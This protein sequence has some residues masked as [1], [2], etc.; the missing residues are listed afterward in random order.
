M[1][2][3]A[4]SP[5]VPADNI[6]PLVVKAA[7]KDRVYAVTCGRVPGVYSSWGRAGAQVTGFPGNILKGYA[8][9]EEAR[10]AFERA[11]ARGAVYSEPFKRA[12]SIIKAEG[13]WSEMR[14]NVDDES[15]HTH[16]R[17][18]PCIVVFRGL[19]TG[20]FDDWL[21]CAEL[22]VAVRGAIFKGYHTREVGERI[23][24]E[25]IQNGD[26]LSP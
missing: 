17:D 3:S 21:D 22:V 4:D 24:E 8:T 15:I 16:V 23:Y 25:A 14:T 13:Q 5:D 9:E 2:T 1:S 10:R 12:R 18:A 20:V 26:I 11:V 19:K 6:R 7:K